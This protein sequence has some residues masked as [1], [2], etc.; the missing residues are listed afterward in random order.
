MSALRR[1]AIG[2]FDV[3]GSLRSD[4]LTL[5]SVL[6]HLLPPII[7][8]GDIPRIVMSD[9]ELHRL[10]LGQS[11]APREKVAAQELVAVS[12]VGELLAVLQP[13]SRG[14]WTPAKNFC[15]AVDEPS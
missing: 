7:A 5:E 14:T 15:A 3:A 4:A 13:D 12:A 9:Q 11:V 8:L 1:E 2:P 6:Q 10:S